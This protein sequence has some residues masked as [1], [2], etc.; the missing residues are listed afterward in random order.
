MRGVGT[1]REQYGIAQ[2]AFA[3]VAREIG[4]PHADRGVSG[5]SPRPL[6]GCAAAGNVRIIQTVPVPLDDPPVLT[7]PVPPH[8][9]SG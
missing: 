3:N 5:W 1:A 4:K 2:A 8:S 6:K 9:L 7:V